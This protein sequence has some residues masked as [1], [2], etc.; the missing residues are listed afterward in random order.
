M[1]SGHVLLLINQQENALKV[2]GK[3]ESPVFGPER[4][5]S[6]LKSI[7]VGHRT[8]P[9]EDH[10]MSLLQRSRIQGPGYIP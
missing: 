4:L 6:M 1:L 2:T 5:L 3:L 8:T 9:E 10:E 7:L